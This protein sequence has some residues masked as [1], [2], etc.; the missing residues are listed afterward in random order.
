M[1]LYAIEVGGEVSVGGL[2]YDAAIKEANRISYLKPTVIRQ[3]DEKAMPVQGE[4]VK[5]D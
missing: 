4:L 1:T 2:S 5:C 3:A